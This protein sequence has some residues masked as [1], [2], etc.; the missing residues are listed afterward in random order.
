MHATATL[1]RRQYAAC[2]C[3]WA[4]GSSH[5]S[6]CAGSWRASSATHPIS[7]LATCQHCRC[8]RHWHSIHAFLSIAVQGTRKATD[9]RD[10]ANPGRSAAIRAM[11]S[12]GWRPG[13][14]LQCLDGDL[15][16]CRGHAAARRLPGPGDERWPAGP[17]RG[18]NAA[19]SCHCW[20][21]GLCGCPGCGRHLW[22]RSLCDSRSDVTG[23]CGL[24]DADAA[25]VVSPSAREDFTNC[26]LLWSRGKG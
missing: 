7:R 24:D 21:A 18:G 20:P 25:V 9:C 11:V 2:R 12:T 5:C 10:L 13:V 3:W 4:A 17:C 14:W 22:R 1:F 16:W 26:R 8:W 19:R 23:F 15:P 6:I